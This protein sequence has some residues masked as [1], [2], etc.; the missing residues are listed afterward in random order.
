MTDTLAAQI[1]TLADDIAAL[2]DRAAALATA[3]DHEPALNEDEALALVD[4]LADVRDRLRRTEEPL[5]AARHHVGRLDRVPDAYE[6]GHA[7]GVV[8]AARRAQAGD[9]TS[10][11]QG[12]V[13]FTATPGQVGADQYERGFLA[14]FADH[15]DGRG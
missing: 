10:G 12:H 14:G 15:F 13:W 6:V 5:R 7:A 8:E 11:D 4:A 3:A 9:A 2:H 1:Q